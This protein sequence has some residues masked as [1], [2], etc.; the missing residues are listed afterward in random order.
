V[1]SCPGPTQDRTTGVWYCEDGQTEDFDCME[2]REDQV[3]ELLALYDGGLAIRFENEK[4]LKTGEARISLEIMVFDGADWRAFE[5]FSGGERY[6]VASAMRL[7]LARLLAHRSGARVSTLLVDEPEGLDA[8]GRAHLATI[9]EHMSGDFGLIM[10]LS[11]Y[12]DLQEAF[13]SQIRVSRD[14]SGFS[15]AEVLA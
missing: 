10:C 6:R 3:N 13:P 11:H 1:S 8:N 2:C 9:L 14:E 15:R 12:S 5:T 4:T 7:G